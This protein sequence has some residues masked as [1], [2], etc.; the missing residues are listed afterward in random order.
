MVEAITFDVGGTLIQPWPSVGEVYRDVAVRHGHRNLDAET[1]NRQF[2]GAW[3]VKEGFDHSRR[4]WRE[5]VEASFAGLVEPGAIAGFFEPL[6]E[7]F[8]APEAWRVFDEAV[9]MLQ[10]L[11]RDGMR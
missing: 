7:Q 5:L 1:L 8:A 10:S 2:V 4:A 6:Y 9:S 3:R 11:R